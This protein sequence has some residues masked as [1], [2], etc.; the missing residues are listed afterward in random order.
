MAYCLAY[1]L[2]D[3]FDL[4]HERFLFILQLQKINDYNVNLLLRAFCPFS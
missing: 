4:L 2:H 1:C 3:R